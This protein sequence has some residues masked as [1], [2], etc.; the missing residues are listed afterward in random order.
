MAQDGRHF[1][2]FKDPIVRSF[3]KLRSFCDE[4]G[5]KIPVPKSQIENDALAMLDIQYF[6]LGIT[7][8]D[9]EN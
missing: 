9:E 6:L 5:M 2:V 7:D 1:L 3:D 8:I 4:R